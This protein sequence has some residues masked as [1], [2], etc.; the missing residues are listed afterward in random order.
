MAVNLLSEPESPNCI[1]LCTDVSERVATEYYTSCER[2]FVPESADVHG[3]YF[4]I[5]VTY[6][7]CGQFLSLNI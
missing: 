1:L 7:S 4:F 2:I 5:S 6:L 3:F